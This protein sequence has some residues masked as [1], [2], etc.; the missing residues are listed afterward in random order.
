[1]SK[2]NKN[3]FLK[4]R[5]KKDIHEMKV[6]DQKKMNRYFAIGTVGFMTLCGLT[7]VSSFARNT[8]DSGKQAKVETVVKKTD[9]VDNR[10][11]VFVENYISAYF[12]FS[13]KDI[14]SYNEK[15]NK[16]Y[17]FVPETKNQ[18]QVKVDTK[19]VSYRLEQISETEAKYRVTYETEGQKLTVLFGVPYGGKEGRYYVSGLPFFQ[20]VVN[21]KADDVEK[22]EVLSLSATDDVSEEDRKT[23]EE[24]LK[25]FFTN[26]TTSQENL[27]IVSKGIKTING[28]VFKSLDYTYFKI[29]SKGKIKAYVQ[30]TFAIAGTT[31]SENFTF[32]I[33]E[34][35]DGTFFVNK[36]EYKIPS[37]FAK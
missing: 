6:I 34:K 9:T 8:T 21:F 19:L 33:T 18:G 25:L 26:Y 16:F 12:N 14:D 3:S 13:V 36:L 23:L 37:D 32:D 27:D 10:L 35:E 5:K 24:F 31:H 4:K 30:A 1:M 17:N 28:A 7:V 2:E 15:L 29:G 11:Q 20:A 22:K